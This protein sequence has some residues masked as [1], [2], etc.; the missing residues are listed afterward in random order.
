MRRLRL[1]LLLLC[2]LYV[3]VQTQAQVP[4]TCTTSDS[5]QEYLRCTLT[6]LVA[7][8]L[9]QSDNTKQSEAPAILPSS[10]TLVDRSSSPD[11][12]GASLNLAGLASKSKSANSSDFSL[13]LSMYGVYAA[14]KSTSPLERQFYDRPRSQTWRRLSFSFGR[15]FPEDPTATVGQGSNSYGAKFLLSH[16]RDP[17]D[18]SNIDDFKCAM[19]EGHNA[20]CHRI[21]IAQSYAQDFVEIQN[22]LYRK[23]YDSLAAQFGREPAFAI[24]FSDTDTRLN[25]VHLVSMSPALFHVLLGKLTG[26]DQAFIVSHLRRSLEAQ[27][28]LTSRLQNLVKDIKRHAQISLGFSSRISKDGGNNLYRTEL[29]VDKGI[30]KISSTTNASYDFQN[31]QKTMTLNRQIGRL[32]EQ[33]TVPLIPEKDPTS[34]SP[35]KLAISGEGDWGTN[36]APIYKAQGKITMTAFSGFDIPFA[37]TYTNKAGMNNKPDLKRQVG[38]AFDFAKISKAFGAKSPH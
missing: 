7:Q 10:T 28:L 8:R 2:S 16:S 36:G 26:E 30:W 22:Y 1:S 12:V 6:N 13:S 29:A 15:S 17:Y 24:V 23:Y 31:A 18:P 19:G 21:D 14:L 4:L 35:G 37:V 27:T 38:F 25:F 33:V 3:A 20:H 11:I 5:L 34:N 32:A 9:R